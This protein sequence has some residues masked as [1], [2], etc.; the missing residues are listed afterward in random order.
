MTASAANP[1]AGRPGLLLR[2]YKNEL[3]GEHIRRVVNPFIRR[4]RP[5][6]ALVGYSMPRVQDDLRG[7]LYASIDTPV[8]RL[9]PEDGRRRLAEVMG[10]QSFT[11]TPLPTQ[12]ELDPD[13]PVSA[14]LAATPSTDA[15]SGTNGEG[16]WELPMPVHAALEREPGDLVFYDGEGYEKVRDFQEPRHSPCAFAGRRHG[17]VLRATPV[18]MTTCLATQPV[19]G[20]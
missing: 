17:H 15:Y 12:I 5:H 3:C 9:D 18:A 8:Q 6:V 20:G 2:E 11:G 1:G 10:A 13:S 4:L 16:F 7:K 14:Y 19:S